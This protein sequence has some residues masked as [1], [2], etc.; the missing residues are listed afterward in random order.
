MTDTDITITV[1]DLAHDHKSAIRAKL[2][3]YGIALFDTS[4]NPHAQFDA[5]ELATDQAKQML[6]N[7]VDQ[8]LTDYAE[9]H[10]IKLTSTTR[11]YYQGR[12][13]ERGSK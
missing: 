11:A 12:E 2:T 8:W 9:E 10:G 1:T 13:D 6:I 7:Y 5:L 3:L 4:P